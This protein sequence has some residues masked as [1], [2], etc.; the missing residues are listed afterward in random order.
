M[1]A[2]V[3]TALFPA[4]PAEPGASGRRLTLSVAPR[5]T[6][7][8]QFVSRA[9]ACTPGPR[10]SGAASWLSPAKAVEAVTEIRRQVPELT[11][12]R[13]AGAGDPFAHAKPTLRTL[14]LVKAEHPDLSRSVATNGVG[15]TPHLDRLDVD[16]VHLTLNTF[17]PAVAARAYPWVRADGV[18]LRGYAAGEHVVERQVSAIRALV[19]RGV[20]VTIEATVR[21]EV[22]LGE[23]AS[24]ASTARELGVQRVTWS[25][26]QARGSGLAAA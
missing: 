12:V 4:R 7:L 14:M 25:D 24:F 19:A 8:C 26:P 2:S 10:R 3:S 18:L 16:A 13:V 5:C 9:A 23:V 21:P 11:W 17:D 20:E 22:G 1:N 15:L 6:P